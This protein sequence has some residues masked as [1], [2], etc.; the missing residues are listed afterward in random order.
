MSLDISTG[1]RTHVANH[2][3]IQ[4]R[5]S[6]CQADK[7]GPGNRPCLLTREHD[8][9]LDQ[10][11]WDRVPSQ[12]EEDRKDHAQRRRR[13]VSHRQQ[14]PAALGPTDT[15]GYSCSGAEAC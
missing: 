1:G 5:Y 11:P 6:F 14:L 8:G 10:S 3:R 9:L 2:K 15:V 13:I 7:K 4:Q 12:E